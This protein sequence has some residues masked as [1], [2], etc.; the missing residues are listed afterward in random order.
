MAKKPTKPAK[1]TK[2]ASSAELPGPST[3]PATNLIMADIAMRAGSSLLRSVVEKNFLSA[4]YDS[5]TA[6]DI[7]NNRSLKHTL[8]SVAVSKMA[9]KSVP[10]AVLVGGGLVLK[11]LFDR[12]QKRRKSRRKGEAALAEQAKD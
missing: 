12:S 2:D 6:R 3:N 4:K 7:V 8:A 10:G 11:T 5:Q 9:T 1:Q